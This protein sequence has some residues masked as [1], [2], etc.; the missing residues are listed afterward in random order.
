M[1]RKNY[2]VQY[3]AYITVHHNVYPFEVIYTAF[4]EAIG[5]A[6]GITMIGVMGRSP[7]TSPGSTGAILDDFLST[8]ENELR[9]NN[10]VYYMTRMAEYI[11]QSS[12]KMVTTMK[13]L[14]DDMEAL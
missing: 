6:V 14:R 9:K 13:S 7:V 8:W 12:R 11:S 4:I 2:N 3:R 10:K 1:N 5:S